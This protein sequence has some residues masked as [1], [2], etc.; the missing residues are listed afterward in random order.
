MRLIKQQL[1]KIYILTLI[2]ISSHPLF[3][4]QVQ[5]GIRDNSFAYLGYIHPAG[6]YINYEN[7]MFVKSFNDQSS[8]IYIGKNWENKSK[9]ITLTGE[10]Y[11]AA[12]WNMSYYNVGLKSIVNYK[13]A[14]PIDISAG[15]MY[16]YDSS[17][18]SELC[19]KGEIKGYLLKGIK[20][21]AG[22]T[23]MP[24]YRVTEKR[25]CLG[26]L[27]ESGNL[28]VNPYISFPLD[29]SLLYTRLLMSFKY[30][31]NIAKQS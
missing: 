3:S 17:I 24:V 22:V 31:I 6:M 9:T 23:N 12:G 26:A 16:Y 1:N 8:G 4:Q 28:S 25:A 21:I 2:L 14:K 19:Y 15:A 5:L 18:G 7:T 13:I 11:S 27:F 30:K 29:D 10:V 20:I